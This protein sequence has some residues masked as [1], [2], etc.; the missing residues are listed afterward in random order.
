MNE[1][2]RDTLIQLNANF[3]TFMADWQQVKQSGFTF[4]HTRKN[5][6]ED[7][8]ATVIWLR[9]T[10]LALVFFLLTVAAGYVANSKAEAI[11]GA[12]G[13]M[14]DEKTNGH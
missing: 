8:Q 14:V 13:V 1:K 5:E 2:D 12:Q 3:N 11:E 6:I 7:V 4:C 10:L 9:N